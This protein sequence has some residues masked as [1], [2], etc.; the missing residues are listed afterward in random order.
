MSKTEEAPIP[1]GHVLARVTK[2]GDGKISTGEH[3]VGEGDKTHPKDAII[4]VPAEA[5]DALEDRG[6]IEAQ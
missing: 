2:K 4:P 5:V 3:V 6:W 1:A